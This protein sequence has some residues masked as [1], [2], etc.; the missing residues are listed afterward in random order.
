ME[1][2]NTY[3][4]IKHQGKELKMLLFQVCQKK[5]KMLLESLMLPLMMWLDHKLL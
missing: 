3:V 2:Q 4:K 1:D 5:L